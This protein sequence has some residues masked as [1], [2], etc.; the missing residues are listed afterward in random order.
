MV[1][2]KKQIKIKTVKICDTLDQSL[3]GAENKNPCVSLQ[4]SAGKARSQRINHFFNYWLQ[5]HLLE[6]AIQRS[7]AAALTTTVNSVTDLHFHGVEDQIKEGENGPP[8]HLPM[9]V[10]RFLEVKAGAAA[11][12][13][14]CLNSDFQILYDY[15]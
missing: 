10:F 13:G 6:A 8:K 12:T 9:F 5:G 15:Y 1:K 2:R 7:G 11:E 4:E 14:L 3:F